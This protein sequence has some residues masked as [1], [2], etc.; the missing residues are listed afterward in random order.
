[1]ISNGEFANET[2]FNNAFMSRT[3]DTSTVG[4]IA[5]LSADAADGPDVNSTQKQINSILSYLGQPADQAFDDLPEWV[6]TLFGASDDTVKEKIEAIMDAFSPADGTLARKSGRDA[7]DSGVD[8]IT[9]A[10]NSAFDTNDYVLNFQFENTVDS[11]PIFLQGRIS[12]RDDE[13]FS[14]KLNAPT[15]SANY[16]L[17][18][19][20]ERR[21]D[22]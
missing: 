8:E 12:A 17:H 16:I 20:C 14:I 18:W 15:D 6:S 21:Q 13:G 5:L 22:P 1:M 19:S 4:K 2:S 9:V 7:I 10:F 3:D 11:T